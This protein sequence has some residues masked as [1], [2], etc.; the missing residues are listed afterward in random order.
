[1]KEDDFQAQDMDLDDIND[2]SEEEITERSL[3]LPYLPVSFY[4]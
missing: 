1:M 3:E 2:L 4:I